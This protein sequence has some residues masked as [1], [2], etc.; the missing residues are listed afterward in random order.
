MT[1]VMAKHFFKMFGTLSPID[2]NMET[3]NWN[4]ILKPCTLASDFQ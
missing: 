1:Q 4:I 2:V 3:Q